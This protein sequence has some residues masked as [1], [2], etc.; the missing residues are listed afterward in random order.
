MFTKSYASSLC[1]K[2]DN[3]LCFAVFNAQHVKAY[4]KG[5]YF[6]VC[7]WD[8]KLLSATHWFT[9]CWQMF[10]DTKSVDNSILATICC[11]LL[12]EFVLT[13]CGNDAQK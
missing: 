4:C 10:T 1:Q 5:L 9:A 6:H 2:Y 8:R 13:K 7:P 3:F 12:A 11:L